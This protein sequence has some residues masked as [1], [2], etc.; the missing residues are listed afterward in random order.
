MSL[1]DVMKLTVLILQISSLLTILISIAVFYKIVKYERQ[2]GQMFKYFLT[3]SITDFF[4]IMTEVLFIHYY[5]NQESF[6]W[7][8]WFIW[9]INFLDISLLAISNYLEVVASFDCYITLNNKFK[10]FH[11]KKGYYIVI[12]IIFT[13]NLV[14]YS[15]KLFVLKIVRMNETINA[16]GS[17]QTKSMIKVTVREDTMNLIEQILQINREFIPF[18][19]LL[20]VNIMI[21]ITMKQISK[22]KKKLQ[23][24]GSSNVNN[25]RMLNAELN[26]TRM[27]LSLSSVF[28]ITRAPI[29]IYYMI[30]NDFEY[31]KRISDL[32]SIF[33][34][35]FFVYYLAQII[36]YYSFNKLFEKH[37]K[38]LF[39]V[40]NT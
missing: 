4:V 5:L 10:F 18:A 39:N 38:A 17:F 21:L 40:R 23:K 7:Q 1:L 14:L 27:I 9:G 8:V 6:F 33:S 37:F 11:T 24:N 28:F 32:N 13:F 20:I 15:T 3:K 34:A 36:F 35:L 31:L 16:T 19:L 12:F 29:T 22:K 25:K 26:K 2:N 30:P